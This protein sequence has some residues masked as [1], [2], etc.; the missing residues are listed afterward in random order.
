[1]VPQRRIINFLNIYKIT[2][3]VIKFIKNQ[4]TWRMELTAGGKTLAVMKI[5]RGTFQGD[6]LSALLFTI[7]MM[8]LYHIIR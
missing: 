6:A 1:M 7:A 5:Q 2:D 4:D 3:D 8:Q